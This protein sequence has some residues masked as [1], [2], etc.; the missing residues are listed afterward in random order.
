VFSVTLH[1]MSNVCKY[2]YRSRYKSLNKNIIDW[3]VFGE[4]KIIS[5]KRVTATTHCNISAHG[6]QINFPNI[7][8]QK[9]QKYRLQQRVT[10]IRV[11][12]VARI[13]VP[14]F[15]FASS[16]I[17]V[18]WYDLNH[19]FF[20]EKF[21]EY[22]TCHLSFCFLICKNLAHYVNFIKSLAWR[23][24]CYADTCLQWIRIN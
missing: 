15:Y 12:S 20:R 10:Y 14:E 6:L 19:H 11:T 2:T 8:T 24:H 3:Q 16:D 21:H 7:C 18:S 1:D 9:T 17:F 13:N 4:N 22:V 23:W 5:T